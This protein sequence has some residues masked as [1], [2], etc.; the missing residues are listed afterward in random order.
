MK[1]ERTANV[2]TFKIVSKL[3]FYPRN[4]TMF[5]PNVNLKFFILCLQ[6]FILFENYAT[7]PAPVQEFALKFPDHQLNQQV[8]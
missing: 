4:A 1:K 7:F 3:F 8:P 2:E 6:K 5:F